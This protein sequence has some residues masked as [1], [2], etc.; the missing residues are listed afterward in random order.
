[1][2]DLKRL[3][4]RLMVAIPSG[5]TWHRLFGLS[6]AMLMGELSAKAVPGYGITEV[7]VN[8]HVGSVLPRSREKLVNLALKGGYSHILFVDSDMVFPADT[9]HRLMAHQVPVVAA[10]C[11]TKQ[12]PSTPTARIR[13]KRYAGS[14]LYSDPDKHGIEKVWRVG[15]GVML[16]AT[17]VF[18]KIKKPWFPITYV[19]DLDDYQGEDWGFCEKLEKA[20]IPIYVDHDLSRL[21]GHC[22]DFTYTHEVVGQVVRVPIAEAK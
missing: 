12:I 2:I 10:N 6:L 14:P 16:I 8:N 5:T 19:P 9:V 3:P 7:K 13:G 21:I 17:H 4:F 15:S 22:G 20:D 18:R 11:A 1:M